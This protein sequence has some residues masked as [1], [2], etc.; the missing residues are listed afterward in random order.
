MLLINKIASVLRGSL[1]SFIIYLLPERYKFIYIYKVGYWKS[2][3]TKSLSGAGSSMAATSNLRN[4]LLDTFCKLNISSIFDV[5]CGDFHWMQN[6]LNDSFDYIGGD[7]V[8]DLIKNNIL[9]YSGLTNVKFIQFDLV[10]DQLPE[11]DC[12]FIRDC[13]VHLNDSDIFKILE[14]IKKSKIKFLFSTSFETDS[15]I[16]LTSADRW[17]PINLCLPPYN[18]PDPLLILNDSHDINKYESLKRMLVWKLN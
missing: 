11:V 5:P 12:I 2:N 10:N 3:N 7:I 14:K 1:H 4:E 16:E 13:L 9:L 15:Q 17:R 18:M 8:P 6:S